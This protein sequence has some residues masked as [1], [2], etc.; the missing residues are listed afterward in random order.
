[1]WGVVTV[2]LLL[3]TSPEQSVGP[4]PAS[5]VE[6]SFYP[7]ATDT[8][9]DPLY[10]T[11][12]STA[13]EDYGRGR[14]FRWMYEDVGALGKAVATPRMLL[15]SAGAMGATLGLAWVDDDII[16]AS[17][18]L[19]DGSARE[20][21]DVVDYLGGPMINGPVVLLAGTSLL[22]GNEKFQDAAFTSLQTLLY[23]GLIGYALK[24]IVGRARP[25]WTDD[26]YKFFETTGK[27]P[28][29]H[30]GNSSF[31]AGHAISSFGI[32]TPWVMYYP[33]AFTYGLYALPVGTA[34]SRAVRKKHWPTDLVVGATIG[35]AMG[36]W[37]SKRHMAE[38]SDFETVELSLLEGS[39]L[40]SV[41]VHIE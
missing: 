13:A 5:P 22:T 18:D 29:S 37:L 40:F 20:V 39:R 38:R 3:S 9:E 16:D 28:F 19:A 30:E 35:V 6:T 14:V 36:R 41:K 10:R 33:N 23:A 12:A 7:V 27:N 31:P 26:P 17:Q 24:G 34:V 21:L 8:L 15:Y 11:E 1:M 4:V 25:E 32:V 2:V